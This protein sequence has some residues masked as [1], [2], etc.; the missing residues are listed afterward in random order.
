MRGEPAADSTRYYAL[1]D[2]SDRVSQLGRVVERDG[3]L[4]GELLHGGEWVECRGV[5]ECLFHIGLGEHVSLAEAERLV[6]QFG[7]SLR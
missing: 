6:A 3:R 2:E 5:L 1:T 4:F 7:G